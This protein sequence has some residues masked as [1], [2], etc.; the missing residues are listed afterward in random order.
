[1][2]GPV[3]FIPISPDITYAANVLLRLSDLDL[4]EEQLYGLFGRLARVAGVAHALD[5]ALDEIEAE[6]TS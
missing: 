2:T 4:R 6:A 1:V 3:D 5:A